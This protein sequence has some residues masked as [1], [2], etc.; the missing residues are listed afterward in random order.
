MISL[1]AVCTLLSAVSADAEIFTYVCGTSLVRIDDVKN[2]L[3]WK[4]IKYSIKSN[5]CG[6]AGWHAQ[7]EGASFD[8]CTATKGYADVEVDGHI[9]VGCNLK[10]R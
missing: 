10:G 5:E 1:A 9:Q 7:G 6:R 8:F 4:G 2:V 3:E